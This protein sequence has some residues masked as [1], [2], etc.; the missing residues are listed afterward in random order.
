VSFLYIDNTADLITYCA[1]A[2]QQPAIA[3]DTEFVRTRTF[4]PQLGLIQIYDGHAVALVDPLAINDITALVDLFANPA[5]VKVLHACS[6]DLETFLHAFDMLPQPIFDTQIAAGYA[7]VGPVMGYGRMVEVMLETTLEKGESRTDWLKRP[8]SPEQL[9]YAAEDVLYLLPCYEKLIASLPAHKIQWV[10][11]EIEQLGLR[12]SA[13][14][15]PQDAYLMFKNTWK[16]APQNLAVLQA[17]GAW[18][19]EYAKTH[20]ITQNFIARETSL[21]EIATKLPTHKGALFQ[22]EMV[23]PQ[24]A[25]KHGQTFVDIVKTVKQRDPASYPAKQYRLTNMPNYKPTF[26]KIKALCQDVAEQVD[27]DVAEIASKR[28]IHQVLTWYWWDYDDTRAWGMQPD[29][30]CGWRAPLLAEKIQHIMQ[31]QGSTL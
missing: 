22:L 24:E 13:Q 29:L 31:E 18:R 7:K 27:C 3:V 19:L 2:S 15:D 16:L 17:L 23:A 10:Y 6:E 30:L 21:Y 4:Y 11:A 14:L 20:D 1:R 12:K 28:Q 5:V 9:Q 25:R 8:L 26:A